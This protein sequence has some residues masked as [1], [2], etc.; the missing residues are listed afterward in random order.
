MAELTAKHTGQTVERVV[1]DADR[2]LWLTAEEALEYGM[3][4]HVLDGPLRSVVELLTLGASPAGC[5][6]GSTGSCR[7][8]ST[9]ATAGRRAAPLASASTVARRLFA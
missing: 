1:A 5:S 4:D 2:D 6:T 3:I 8:A 7:C 9:S